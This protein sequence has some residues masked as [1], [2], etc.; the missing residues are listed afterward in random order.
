MRRATRQAPQPAM[1]GVHLG[2]I[3][4]KETGFRVQKQ[5]QLCFWVLVE[6]VLAIKDA[7]GR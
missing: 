7:G 3:R 1:Q 5:D 2:K 6:A 4:L